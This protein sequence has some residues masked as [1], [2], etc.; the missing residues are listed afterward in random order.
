MEVLSELRSEDGGGGM[1][2][3]IKG[4]EMPKNCY[5][6]KLDLRTDICKTFC[7]WKAEHP[8]SIPATD[9][10]PDCPL[11]KV[12]EPHGA[13]IDADAL[14]DFLK[15]L[16]PERGMWEID[17]DVGKNAVCETVAEAI[18][19]VKNME[20]VKL[21]TNSSEI[22]NDSTLQSTCNQ[23]T[24]DT[25]SRQAAKKELKE[26]V[27]RNYT[28]EFWGAMQVLDE[29]PSAQPERKTGH[30]IRVAGMNECCSACNKYF[31]L[32]YFTGRPFD[33]NYCPNCGADMRG[34]QNG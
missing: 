9:R 32:S 5:E 23:L 4:M 10:L 26:K 22:P 19:I 13:L 24:T 7:E 30:W 8:Y 28:D 21:E 12:P 18:E 11:V 17:G 6:C 33:I 14:T 2:V 16:L 29:L 27:F 25:I 1:S 31:P 3:F 20:T 34:E 15:C